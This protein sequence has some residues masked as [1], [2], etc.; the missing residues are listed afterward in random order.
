M[1][2]FHSLI[3][4]LFI[5]LAAGPAL[6]CGAQTDCPLTTPNGDARTYRIHL[7]EGGA[8]T[9]AIVHAHGYRGSAQGVM[10]N[11]A[12]LRLAG[13]LG[14]ALIAVNADDHPDWVLP[15]APR[16]PGY[17]GRRELDYVRAVVED[18]AA[19]FDIPRGRMMMTGFSAGGMLT[20]NVLCDDGALFAG[21]VPLSGVFWDPI[22]PACSGASA[23]II[24]FHGMEDPVV[25]MAG[26]PIRTT[27]QGDVREALEMYQRWGGYGAA[28]TAKWDDDLT[29]ERRINGDGKRLELCLFSGG[30]SL[31]LRDIERAWRR[32]EALGVL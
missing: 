5:A 24:H 3:A 19:R 17:S 32:F 22:P 26:R 6:A 21:Y 18:A 12:M 10:N 4:A 7:P 23:N 25:P 8:P 20:W 29:C 14:V 9:G 2:V 15:G 11:K 28:E 27:T 30:H 31:R 1:R 13:R 16:D